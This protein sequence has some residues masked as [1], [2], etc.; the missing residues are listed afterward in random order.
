MFVRMLLICA[1]SIFP[2]SGM[3]GLASADGG[4]AAIEKTTKADS[5]WVSIIR[6]RAICFVI[7]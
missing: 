4:H 5:G 3:P 7:S 1:V 6:Q 2:I